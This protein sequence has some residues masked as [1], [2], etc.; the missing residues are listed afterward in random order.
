MKAGKARGEKNSKKR[1]KKS[2][3]YAGSRG[4]HSALHGKTISRHSLPQINRVLARTIVKG[5]GITKSVK[6]KGEKRK[7]IRRDTGPR[8]GGNGVIC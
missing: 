2:G 7:G 1:R 3:L 4:R 8:T 5:N 6:G